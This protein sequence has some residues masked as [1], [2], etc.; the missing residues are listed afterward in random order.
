ML[1]GTRAH[2]G[3]PFVSMLHAG[4]AGVAALLGVHHTQGSPSYTVWQPCSGFMATG[5]VQVMG[6]KGMDK[7]MKKYDLDL[8]SAQDEV[9]ALHCSMG[10]A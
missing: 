2:E 6:T 5:L 3:I 8:N 1:S 7:Y 10:V 4:M 9:S